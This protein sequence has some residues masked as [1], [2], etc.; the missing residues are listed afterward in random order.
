MARMPT[1][2][3]A[4]SA[5]ELDAIRRVE[6]AL[7]RHGV[8][9]TR[10]IAQADDARSREERIGPLLDRAAEMLPADEMERLRQEVDR[11]RGA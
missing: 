3:D 6:D 7:R 9:P 5:G 10:D 2:D 8:D 1:Y 4:L 11:I